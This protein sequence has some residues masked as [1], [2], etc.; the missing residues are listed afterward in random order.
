MDTNR[1]Q[2]ALIR[3][4]FREIK[5]S[6][7]VMY[8]RE[9]LYLLRMKHSI[10]K[11]LKSADPLTSLEMFYDTFGT[12]ED[13]TEIYFS[14][15]S[16]AQI[17]TMIRYQRYARVCLTCISVILISLTA[18]WGVRKY[19]EYDFYMDLSITEVDENISIIDG[20]LIK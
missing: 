10:K 6:F 13:I 7:P 17:Y 2:K 9:R 8:I 18:L 19:I 11:Q 5:K 16:L 3:Q 15:I 4:Y 20:G 12:P 1:L 14:D